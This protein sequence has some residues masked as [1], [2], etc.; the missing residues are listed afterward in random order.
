VG[1]LRGEVSPANVRRYVIGLLLGVV[2][3]YVNIGVAN[4]NYPMIENLGR[5]SAPANRVTISEG[6]FLS[7]RERAMMRTMERD[8]RLARALTYIR[9]GGFQGGVRIDM[10]A[11]RLRLGQNDTHFDPVYQ[12][13]NFCL[14]E[15][16]SSDAPSRITVKTI[17]P[18][19]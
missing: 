19:V 3:V 5:A 15:C 11:C 16:P 13:I 7:A 14:R 17:T 18:I 4:R 12:Y 9:R 6:K 10:D 1:K 2:F 8:A